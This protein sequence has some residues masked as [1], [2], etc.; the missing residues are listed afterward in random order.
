[1]DDEAYFNMTRAEQ[2]SN[3]SR[4]TIYAALRAGSLVG[5]KVRGRRLFRKTD[6]IAWIEQEASDDDTTN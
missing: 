2:F 6:L 4:P 1:M 5:L 3:L